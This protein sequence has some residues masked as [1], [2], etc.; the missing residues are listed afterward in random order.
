MDYL[1]QLYLP[2]A[3]PV[4]AA[5]VFALAA[6]F[7]YAQVMS[8]KEEARP[9][10][11][12]AY[13]FF[14]ISVV[15]IAVVLG[16]A[17]I[18]RDFRVEYVFQYSGLELP[19]HYQFAAFWAGQKGSFLIWLVWGSLLGLLIRRGAGK[20]EAPVMAI[21]TLTVTGLLAILV[22]ENPFVMLAETPF[23]GQGLNP[24]LQD[25]WMVIHP[26]IMFVG[27]ALAAV[28]FA[29]AMAGL[30]T[31]DYRSWAARAY[32]WA[33]AGFLVLGAAILMGGYWAYKTL[34]WGGYWG[35]DPVENASLIPWLLLVVLIHGLHLERAKGRYRKANVII[36]S[37]VYLS[38]LYGTFLTRS[39]VLADFSVHS[40]VDL[41]ISGWLIALMVT[42]IAIPAILIPLRWR[43]IPAAKNVDPM[44]SRGAF[45]VLSTVTVLLSAA[46]ITFGTSAPLLTAFF[47][48]PG[49]VG[50]EFYN[51]VNVP[52]ALLLI[53]LL[54]VVPFLTW[55]GVPFSQVMH[56]LLWPAVG[57]LVVTAATVFFGVLDPIHLGIVFFSLLAIVTNIQKTFERAGAGGMSAAGG[58]LAHVGVGVILI[59]FLASSAYDHSA[60]VTLPMGEPVAIDG[61][62]L[63]FEQM[64]PRQ[65]REK[66]RMQ[67]RVVRDDG[68]EYVAYPKLFV[69]DRTR[70]TMA[71]PD[72]R[73]T[74]LQDLY[75]SP[76]EF[77]PGV[78]PGQPRSFQLAEGES[79]EIGGVDVSFAGFDFE[80]YNSMAPMLALQEGGA[81]TIAALLDLKVDGE[82]TRVSPL[83]RFSASGAIDAQPLVLPMGG[84]VRVSG[85]NANE[86]KVQID[87]V[88]LGTDAEGQPPRLA[89]DVTRKPLIQLVWFGL[90]IILFGGLLAGWHRWQQARQYDAIMAKAEAV[91]ARKAVREGS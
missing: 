75:I 30:W 14:T 35:W 38:V 64:I 18:R 41:G 52:L 11:R 13:L 10:A 72:V 48:N 32:P 26:P 87:V 90:Y 59:G 76:L 17:L 91:R 16:I 61:L 79:E 4:W 77:D 44:L 43:E 78:Q 53:L 57:A 55:R 67:V 19:V 22:R 71:H 23:D 84:A 33:L 42:F 29:F 47:E 46:V 69:N 39:G 58:W 25:D 7:G 60:K 66:E 5:L 65:G 3:V 85:I 27:F 40:F 74:P 73:T 68:R 1:S 54:A 24:L 15:L 45:L 37:L 56:K 6:L 51:M 89:I 88:G 2:G 28:P 80:S 49:Q 36:A 31:R 83:Y 62:T 34:G 20:L 8:G 86:G 12:R 81:V 9:F 50:P 82:T 70:Q 21:Y 63:T